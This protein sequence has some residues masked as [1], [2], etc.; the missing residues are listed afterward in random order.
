[1][2]WHIFKKD[3]VLLWPVVLLS[4]LAQ[5]GLTA[6]MFAADNDPQSQYLLLTARLSVIVVFLAIGLAITLAVHQDPIPGTRQ[7]WLIRPI[8][9]RDLL[10]AKL[11]FVLL[12]VQLPMFLGDLAEA[13]SHGFALQDALT[14][15]LGRNLYVLVTLSLPAFGIA[16]MTRSPAQTIGV[17]VV[18]FIAVVAATFLLSSVARIGGQ[19]QATNPLA[20]TG[21]A[22]IEQSAS[23]AVLAAGAVVVLL[24][25][26]LKRRLVLAWSLFPAFAALSALAILLPWSWLFAVQEAAAASPSAAQAIR[27]A[28]EP[29]APRYRPP[30]G[31]SSDDYAIGAAQV[32]L[33][34][35]SAGDITEENRIRRSRGDVTVFAPVSFRGLPAGAMPWADRA[36]VTLVQDGKVV[37]E[38]RGDDL[39]LNPAPSG[40]TARGGYEAI[41]IP[42]LV[43]EVA[44]GKPS[45]LTIDYS[46]TLLTPQPAVRAAAL[47]ADVQA[48]GLGRCTSG[49]DS[50]G[51]DIELRCLSL[52]RTPSCLAVTLEDGRTGQRNP[53]N[54][55]CAP[56]Y[57]PYSSRSFPDAINRFEIEAPFR[58]RFGVGRYPV[59][60][61]QLGQARLILTRYEPVVH[62]T[63]RVTA[64][65]V[66]LAD[67]T[68]DP[69]ASR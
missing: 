58:D 12:A 44:R 16:A 33:R 24:L 55:I 1:M 36:A 68:A 62:L 5:F 37:F 69:G 31:S 22:W 52:A 15:A 49:R 2:A 21:V 13:L 45:T 27:V 39:K 19:E 7:D 35:R 18:Y 65:Q 46:L 28:L 59:T 61:A 38:G 48:P 20:W 57:S 30:P 54:L 56:D 32:Q 64:S 67:W 29:A 23:R 60:G 53:E 3:F 9:R 41:R 51:D 6:L 10:V 25:L 34:G 42:A 14:A 66:R 26:Y 8:R 47:G 4:A 63:R 43:F 40:Q 17:G 50:D 11:L